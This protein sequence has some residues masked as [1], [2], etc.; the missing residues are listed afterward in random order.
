MNDQISSWS[1]I[2]VFFQSFTFYNNLEK[3]FR[4]KVS[5]FKSDSTGRII[6]PFEAFI[7][8]L[9]TKELAQLRDTYLIDLRELSHAEF[10]GRKKMERFDIYISEIFHEVSILKEQKFILEHYFQRKDQM[11]PEMINQ[12]LSQTY[13]LFETKMEHVKVLFN[14][15]KSRLEEIAPTYRNDDFI[16]RTLYLKGAKEFQEFYK[17]PVKNILDLMFIEGGYSEG[18]LAIACSFCSGG[19]FEQGQ[20]VISEIKKE[21][22]KKFK[23][24]VLKLYKKV[25]L[26]LKD[27]SKKDTLGESYKSF[28]AEI[29]PDLYII[30][31]I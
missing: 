29:V 8:F 7:E 20:K 14:S 13:E 28:I 17:D 9:D 6:Y 18:Y 26:F 1:I 16:L 15:A 24:D 2:K 30:K 4:E 5:V 31:Q 19:F 22:I 11:Y 27:H 23:P 10:R 3:N 12:M 25:N 21:E